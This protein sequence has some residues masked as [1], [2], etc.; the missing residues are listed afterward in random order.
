[1]RQ[2][3][4]RHAIFEDIIGVD[5]LAR[6][7]RRAHRI[8]ENRATVLVER[9]DRE[10]RPDPEMYT[11]LA[12]HLR[13]EAVKC[14]DVGPLFKAGSKTGHPPFHLV[15]CRKVVGDTFAG[16]W[17]TEAFASDRITYE[18]SD[19]PK[20]GLYLEALPFFMRGAVTIPDH[21]S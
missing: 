7:G 19:M 6:D 12:E 1:M 8:L 11:V 2:D 10:I 17:V 4:A 18:R 5:G 9:I 16:D 13:T 20:S 3:G 15:G 14:P 21:P